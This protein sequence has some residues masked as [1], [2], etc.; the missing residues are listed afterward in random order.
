M[1][2][3]FLNFKKKLI[4]NKIHN[5]IKVSNYKKFIDNSKR[6]LPFITQAKYIGSFFVTRTIKRNVEKTDER[7]TEIKKVNSKIYTIF[8]SKWNGCVTTAE[9]LKKKLNEEN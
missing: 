9:Q 2:P 4:N 8:S 7:T 3:R 5:N 1:L 6:Y